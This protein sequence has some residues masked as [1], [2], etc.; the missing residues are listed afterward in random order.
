ML[1]WIALELTRQRRRIIGLLAFGALFS[2]AAVTARLV[3]GR[4]GHVEFDALL[5]VG[6]YP[7]VSALLLTGWL[8]G[9]F[10]LIA[11]LVLM[12]GVYSDQHH[13]RLPPLL[14]VPPP[15]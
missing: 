14:P 2:A 13:T 6:G 15:H 7:M 3:S 11:V 10:P 8:V 9:R 1:V 4:G 12:A 5:Q